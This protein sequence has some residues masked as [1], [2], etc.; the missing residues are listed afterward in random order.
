MIRIIPHYHQRNIP[1][2]NKL[3]SSDGEI[4]ESNNTANKSVPTQ[5]QMRTS[6]ISISKTV[7][8]ALPTVVK[9][10]ETCINYFIDSGESTTEL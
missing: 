3:Y 2:K 9:L 5:P 10:S 6:E 1:Q 8:A 7:T 4:G